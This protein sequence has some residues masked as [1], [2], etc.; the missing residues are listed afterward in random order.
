MPCLKTS[1]TRDDRV[2]FMF[3]SFIKKIEEG[4][5][6][7][8]KEAIDVFDSMMQGRVDEAGM[9]RFLTA[10]ADRGETAG[11]IT[12]AANVLRGYMKP[13]RAPAGTIDCCGTGGDGL[14]T[15]NISTAVAFIVAAC[16]VPVAK[17]GNRAASS[18]SGAADVLEQLGANLD[19]STQALEKNLRDIGFCFLMAPNHHP[20]MK[21]VAGVRKSLGR[22]TIFNLLGPLLNPAG[23]KRQ[24]VGVPDQKWLRPMAESLR[25]LGSEKAWVVNAANGMDEISLDGETHVVKLDHGTMTDAV[26]TADDFGLPVVAVDDI[27]GGNAATNATAMLDLLKN[28]DTPYRHIVLANAAA[29]LCIAGHTDNLRDAVK[30]ARL[31]IENG[32]AL[33]VLLHYIKVK[34]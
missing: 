19:M 16:G 12:S 10:L 27:K 24:L 30:M 22:R 6:L 8:D 33:N 13:V 4:F 7:S 3:G 34:D 32:S 11:E 1:L 29:A 26:L 18:R 21:Q 31:S 2:I 14:H 15:L 28:I 5:V 25:A 9:G 23:V 17:H 20:A